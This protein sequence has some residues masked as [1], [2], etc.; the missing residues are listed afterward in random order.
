[1]RPCIVPSVTKL[2][3]L[4]ETRT[5]TLTRRVREAIHIRLHPNNINRD[6]GTDIPEAWMPTVR[7]HKTAGRHHSGPLMD[8]FPP[9]T[10][11]SVLWI[12]THQPWFVIHQSLTT[13]VV[14][15]VRLSRSAIS[16]DEDLQCVVETSRSISKCQ[17]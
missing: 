10:I 6:G 4:T 7:Q 17:K 13:R 14:P 12:E 8:Q 3:L 2:S 5:G 11:P 15:I 9:L 16:P 1:M